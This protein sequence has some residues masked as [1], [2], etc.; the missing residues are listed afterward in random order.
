VSEGHRQTFLRFSLG[1]TASQAVLGLMMAGAGFWLAS[2]YAFH[3]HDLPEPR[4][5]LGQ[6]LSSQDGVPG[7]IVCSIVSLCFAYWTMRA[8]WRFFSAGKAAV[9][10]ERGVLF[11]RSSAKAEIPY[12]DISAVE[13]GREFMSLR[14]LYIRVPS[15][16]RIRIQ[17][18]EVEGGTEALEAFEAELNARRTFE[19]GSSG[20]ATAP[21]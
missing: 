21:E 9:L 18:N 7:L 14:N 10:T 5:G 11:H 1:G 8:S 2:K 4:S 15:R 13:L 16:R 17:S 12:G 6:I 20:A 19:G 3:P